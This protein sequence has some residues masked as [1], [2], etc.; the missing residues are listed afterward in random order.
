LALVALVEPPTLGLMGRTVLI[1]YLVQQPQLVVVV[2]VATPYQQQMLQVELL[3]VLAAAG[4]MVNLAALGHL[5]KETLAAQALLLILV[6]EA[7]A[8]VPLAITVVAAR[9]EMAAM[10]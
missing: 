3:E 2:V 9:L 8:L 4:R 6:V 5:G 7:A 1:L 10:V